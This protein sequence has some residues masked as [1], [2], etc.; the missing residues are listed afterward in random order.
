M[1]SVPDLAQ[2]PD[3]D[4]LVTLYVLDATSQGGEV[5]RFVAA[6][7]ALRE[8]SRQN[9][10]PNPWFAGAVPGTQGTL[11]TGVFQLT[12]TG[13]TRQVLGRGVEDGLP[14]VDLRWS[15]T[16]SVGGFVGL[17]FSNTLTIPAAANEP[18][19]YGAYARLLAGGWS[20][21]LQLRRQRAN[22]AGAAQ[23]TR[24]EVFALPTNAPLRGQRFAVAET[25]TGSDTAFARFGLFALISAGGAQDLTLRFGLPQY[26]RNVGALG[27]PLLPPA[28]QLEVATL[29]PRVRF[30]GQ[31]YQ[32][33]PIEAEGFAWTGRGAPPRPR[34]R[35]AN[36]G[37]VLGGL[38]GPGGDL[39]GATLTRL[40]TFR[41]FLDGE[42][43]AD[44]SAHF[45][46]DI[47]RLE[48]KTRQDA[49]LVE[50]ELA[51]VLEQEGRRLPG[52][53]MLRDLCSHSYRR[54]TGSSFDYAAA[55]CPYTGAAAFTEAGVPTWSSGD[56]CGKR[57]G[58]C[59]LRFG[60]GAVL[61]TRAFP[62]LGRIG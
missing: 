32:P 38:L 34:L 49:V 44:P 35:V 12:I 19:A 57:L 1:A 21:S 16:T 26:E 14:Y 39:L 45:E 33:L 40:R 8:G 55:S 58:D 51:S 60:V 3:A 5:L 2:R 37:G 43:D 50:W 56:R 47:W 18:I 13:L 52:R 42:P 62:G 11:P 54:W 7:G 20:G 48:R 53:Q 30:Q 41:R 6:A 61:P 29:G 27:G 36:I 4:A 31:D 25:L 17:W 10:L 59:Q 15:G 9:L 24:N 23:A 22:A 46:P 28:D